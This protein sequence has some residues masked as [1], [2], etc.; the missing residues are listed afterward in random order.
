MPA[1]ILIGLFISLFVGAAGATS[2]LAADKISALENISAANPQ[3]G[4]AMHR[5][6]RLL[7]KEKKWNY[8]FGVSTF[9]QVNQFDLSSETI[10]KKAALDILA[11]SQHCLFD[12]ALSLAKQF[13]LAHSKQNSIIKEAKAAVELQNAYQ[14]KKSQGQKFVSTPLVVRNN[15]YWPIATDRL[16]TIKHPKK[17]RMA[18]RSQCQ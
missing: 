18:V 4:E 10:Q 15:T 2:S 14:L 3:F 17:L 7:Y 12:Q 6:H 8:F 5:L 1:Q 9:L 16:K 13:I 11:L